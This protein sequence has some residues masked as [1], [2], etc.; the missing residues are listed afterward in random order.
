[1]FTGAESERKWEVGRRGRGGRKESRGRRQRNRRRRR[2]RG[3]ERR[4][5]RGRKRRRMGDRRRWGGGGGKE[6]LVQ[7]FDNPAVA[8][9]GHEH[10][11][12]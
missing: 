7:T 8:Q 12:E 6:L 10:V 5:M 9:Q 11:E 4:R 1:L 3:K 2:K